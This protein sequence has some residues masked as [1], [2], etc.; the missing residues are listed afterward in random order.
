MN[1]GDTIYRLRT[2]KNMSQGDLADALGVSRQS[3]SKWENGNATPD[4]DK[5]VKLAKLFGVTLDELVGSQEAPTDA[6][7]ASVASAKPNIIYIEKSVLPAISRHH[8]I[9]AVLILCSLIYGLILSN[10][11]YHLVLILLLAS[12]VALCGVLFLVTHTPLLFSGWV[13]VAAGWCH[14]LIIFH[15]WENHPFLILL[16]VAAVI[17]M[18][19]LTV[20]AHLSRRIHIPL[21]LWMA[22][23]ILLAAL[24]LLLC[25]NCIP[26]VGVSEVEHSAVPVG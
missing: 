23:G 9:G 17:V 13:L 19:L 1:L 22:G 24:F 25:M 2:E 15:R 14:F 12:P 7:S 20:R 6:C 11:G 16:G 26:S 18:I 4:L 3:V 21:W 8:I 10:D 5:L